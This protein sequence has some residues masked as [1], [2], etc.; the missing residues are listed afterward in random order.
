MPSNKFSVTRKKIRKI[1]EKYLLGVALRR[2]LPE[3]DCLV[4]KE[5]IR[6]SKLRKIL[7]RVL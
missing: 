5:N 4:E 3:L 1:I 2:V 6:R 7:R